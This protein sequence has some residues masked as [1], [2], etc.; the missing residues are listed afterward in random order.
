MTCNVKHCSY[1]VLCDY[2]GAALY[3][4]VG[5]IDNSAFVGA[6][7]NVIVTVK[8]FASVGNENIAR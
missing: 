4:M 1:G 8:L 7:L 2:A 5:H 6:V 3:L